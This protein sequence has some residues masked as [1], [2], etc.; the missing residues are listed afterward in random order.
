MKRLRLYTLHFAYR[1]RGG[2]LGTVGLDGPWDVRRVLGTVPVAPDGSACFRIPANTP[3]SLQ[4]LDA[5]GKA[6]QQMRSW[7]VGMPGEHIS[8]LGCHEPQDSAPAAADSSVLDA[9][10][11]AIHSPSEITPWYGPPRNFS[12]PREVQ[13]VIDRLCSGCHDGSRAEAATSLPDFRGDVLTTDYR[14][15]IDGS[16]GI[17]GRYFSEAY[18]QF[19]R[20]VRRPGI[21]SDMRRCRP[22]SSTPIRQIWCV[23]FARGTMACNSTTRIGTG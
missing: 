1:G 12:F 15:Q 14:T 3:V 21:E 7:F 19:S 17:G 9:A 22:V 10:R 20:F 13:P 4:P 2:L 11:S 6:L 23:C 5:E 8:C 16:S 18:F